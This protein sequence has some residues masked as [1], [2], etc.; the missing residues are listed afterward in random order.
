MLSESSATFRTRFHL[1]VPGKSTIWSGFFK[2]WRQRR[3]AARKFLKW[4]VPVTQ[5]SPEDIF[6][7]GYPKSGN[8]WFQDLITAVVYGVSPVL[9]PPLLAQTL[10]PD[11]HARPFYQR[12]STPMFFKSHHHPRPEY[13]RVVYLMRDGRDV[14]VSYCHYLNASNTKVDLFEMVQP[15]A[16]IPQGKWHDHVNAWLSNPYQAQMIVIKYEDLKRDTVGELARF[17]V[18]AGMERDR[19]F[20]EMVARETVFEKMQ[21]KE[22]RL[23]EGNPEWPRDKLF[24]RRGM[25]GSYK[26]EMP[27]DVL[28]AFMAEAGGTLKKCGYA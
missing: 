10:V 28:Q 6:I 1:S 27:P 22:M 4:Y 11:V 3:N 12:F 17:C 18:F 14:M 16:D 7:V 20:L 5:S 13:K 25:T 2:K 19:S 8:T 9:G 24:R 15:D 23:G 21:Q 26:D